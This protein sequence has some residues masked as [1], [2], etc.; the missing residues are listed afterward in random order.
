MDVEICMAEY[1]SPCGALTMCSYC[2]RMCFCGWRRPRLYG[3]QL[4][5]IGRMAAA[6]MP[7]AEDVDTLA[8]AATQLDEYFSGERRRFE[9]DLLPVGTDFQREVW[10]ELER[11]PYGAVISYG[12]L[13]S[14]S[15]R[16]ERAGARAVARAVGANPLSLFIPCHRVVGA[17]G[18]LTGYAGGLEAKDFLLRLEAKKK[19]IF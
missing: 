18:S 19:I 1:E 13:A 14:A 11:I 15:A 8:R 7:A 3:R 16:L 5:R 9:L 2:G 17:D 6:G 4:L 10:K 12:E